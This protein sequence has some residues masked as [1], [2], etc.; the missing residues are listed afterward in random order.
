[1]SIASTDQSIEDRLS[2]LEAKLG[3]TASNN[4]S[5]NNNDSG[6]PKGDLT[7]R[8]DALESQWKSATSS[9]FHQTWDESD[10]LL[11]D[12]SPG[13]SLLSYQQSATSQSMN[14]PILYR[15]QAVLASQDSLRRD[16]SYL[17]EILNLLYISQKQPSN[18]TTETL[19]SQAPI[20]HPVSISDEEERR[21][22]NLRVNV[23]KTQEQTN[24]L[25]NR[26]D[27]LISTYQK[28][29]FALSERIILV[30]EKLSKQG[31]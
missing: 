9:S 24:Q 29:I 31:R 3:V 13:D 8:L 11:E 22:D 14:N 6:R 28:A 26:V 15:K 27:S 1:M 5:N 25:V 20:L 7:N 10:R 23:I 2:S 21:L 16:M 17:S 12:L 19:V 18:S 4:N 30:E